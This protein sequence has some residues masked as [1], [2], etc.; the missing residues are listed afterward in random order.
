M[1]N[2]NECYNP[3]VEDWN[4]K[5]YCVRATADSIGVWTMQGHGSPTHVAGGHPLAMLPVA[6]VED[7][8]KRPYTLVWV[9]ADRQ[10]ARV[11]GFNSTFRD[12]NLSDVRLERA[13][14]IS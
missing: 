4:P 5:D 10:T 2:A 14:E 1:D 11:V 9:N 6:V 8:Q 13:I 3:K 7:G 12:V